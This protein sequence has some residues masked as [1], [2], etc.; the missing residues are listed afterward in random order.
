MLFFLRKNLLFL[1]SWREL[2]SAGEPSL[3]P[4]AFPWLAEP[5]VTF[6]WTDKC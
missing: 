1:R 2:L 3:A 5:V 4:A 6:L